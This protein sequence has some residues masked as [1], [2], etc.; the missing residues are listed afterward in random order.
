MEKKNDL[1]LYIVERDKFKDDVIVPSCIINLG[2][3]T[4]AEL[5]VIDNVYNK[6]LKPMG[7]DF[8][9]PTI[10]GTITHTDKDIQEMLEHPPEVEEYFS[11]IKCEKFNEIHIHDADYDAPLVRNTIKF[12]R[13][14]KGYNVIVH[15]IVN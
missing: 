8:G 14:L 13:N 3:C 1:I 10:G 7:R 6:L 12:I 5:L 11:Y 2:K 9:L 15:F 4:L